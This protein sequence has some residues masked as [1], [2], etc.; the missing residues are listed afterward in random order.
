ME[1]VLKPDLFLPIDANPG[2]W[3]QWAKCPLVVGSI[4]PRGRIQ[5]DRASWLIRSARSQDWPAGELVLYVPPRSMYPLSDYFRRRDPEAV[6]GVTMIAANGLYSI[7]CVCTMKDHELKRTPYFIE[8]GVPPQR[9]HW[10]K[11]KKRK[12]G[13][14]RFNE[15]EAI[16]ARLEEGE[17]K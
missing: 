16:L 5:S 12:E 2:H 3:F 9:G 13:L 15:A 17:T 1:A 8:G 7:A 11:G 14:R 4:Y 10:P 6:V